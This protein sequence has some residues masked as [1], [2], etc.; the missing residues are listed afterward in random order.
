MVTAQEA[1]AQLRQ[2]GCDE[3]YTWYD[4]PDF[5]YAPHAHPTATAHIIIEGQMTITMDGQ[6]LTLT[7][8]QRID[9]PANMEHTAVMGPDGCT[10]VVGEKRE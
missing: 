9:V 10:Y 2:E 5:A 4:S 7:P 3:V 6:N 8:G 1:E